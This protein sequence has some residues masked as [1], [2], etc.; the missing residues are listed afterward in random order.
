SAMLSYLLGIHAALID[1]VAGYHALYGHIDSL[2]MTYEQITKGS[3][4]Y[5]LLEAMAHT[6]LSGSYEEAIAIVEDIPSNY[7]LTEH[8]EQL[9]ENLLLMYEALRWLA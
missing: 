6:W 1:S 2:L 8:E 3:Y 5:R 4:E 7:A 9:L